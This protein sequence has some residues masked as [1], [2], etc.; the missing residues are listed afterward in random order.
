MLRLEIKGVS[1]TRDRLAAL[2]A[3]LEDMQ[4]LWDRY[5]SI[6]SET[7]AEWF[8]SEGEGSWPPLAA[9][10]ARYKLRHGWPPETLIRRGVL[11]ESL[12]DPLQAMEVSQGRSTLGTFTRKAMTWGTDARDDRGREYAH[13][14]QNV[15]PVTGEPAGYPPRPPERQVIPWPLPLQTRAKMQAADEDWVAE[16]IRRSGL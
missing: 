6:M 12:V 9:S 7:E 10:T 15:D 14:H 1:E 13:Y 2:G 4:G 3:Q 8:A 16:A 5:A 11:V